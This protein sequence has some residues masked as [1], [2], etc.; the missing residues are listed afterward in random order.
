MACSHA[1]R[2]AQQPAVAVKAVEGYDML[3]CFIFLATTFGRGQ[4]GLLLSIGLP[5]LSSRAYMS[6]QHR[7][8]SFS[9]FSHLASE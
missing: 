1:H 4:L 9:A 3:S 8:K 7:Y 5:S 6:E 2:G